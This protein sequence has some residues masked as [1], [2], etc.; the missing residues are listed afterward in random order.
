M[1]V[2]GTFFLIFTI[3]I[4][5]IFTDMLKPIIVGVVAV[6]ALETASLL[7][8]EFAPYSIT[9]I[10]SGAT[11]FRTGELPWIGLGVSLA[12]AAAMFYLSLRIVERRDF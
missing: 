9:R 5:T 6:F 11:Y 4:S 7:I 8:K 12:V 3:L 10:M 1:V 2:G